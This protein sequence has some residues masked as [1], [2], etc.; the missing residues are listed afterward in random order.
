MNKYMLLL[1]PLFSCVKNKDATQDFEY[2]PRP[3]IELPEGDLDD[4]PEAND[5]GENK[6]I[7]FN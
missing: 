6:E 1:L 5:T 3:V 2:I 4:L 7:Y